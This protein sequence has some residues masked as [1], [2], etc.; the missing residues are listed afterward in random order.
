MK[1]TVVTRIDRI[2]EEFDSQE[3]KYLDVDDDVRIHV[4]YD[5]DGW[6]WDA[7]EGDYI[8]FMSEESFETV[9]EAEADAKSYI[10]NQI[11]DEDYENPEKEER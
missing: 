4:Y 11:S 2:S 10:E 6:V 7:I 1:Q 3:N 9:E 8:T 5:E